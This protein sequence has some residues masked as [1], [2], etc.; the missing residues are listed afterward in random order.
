MLFMNNTFEYMLKNI[1]T[2][3]ENFDHAFNRLVDVRSDDKVLNIF[4]YGNNYERKIGYTF[5]KF[6]LRKAIPDNLN[7]VSP[8]F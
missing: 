7:Q 4:K 6:L 8:V 3:Y 1:E 2:F 5:K